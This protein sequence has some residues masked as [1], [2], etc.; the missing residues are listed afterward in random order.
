ML[1]SAPPSVATLLEVLGLTWTDMLSDAVQTGEVAR[2]R[3]AVM[4][5]LMQNH[6]G[7]NPHRS[8]PFS[9]NAIGRMVNRTGPTVLAGARR[10]QARLDAIEAAYARAYGPAISAADEG[11]AA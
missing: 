6:P 8:D 3:D 7:G 10:H 2:A 1:L 11:V 4:W 5:T 9:A